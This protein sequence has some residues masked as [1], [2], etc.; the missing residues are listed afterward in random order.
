MPA[1]VSSVSSASLQSA[2][3]SSSSSRA[4]DSDGPSFDDALGKAQGKDAQPADASP[5]T[6]VAR[7]AKADADKT[8]V[9]STDKKAA[10]TAQTTD[11]KAKKK[12]DSDNPP[13]RGNKGDGGSSDG[14]G[15]P[16]ADGKKPQPKTPA[17]AKAIA[18]DAPAAIL[19][20]QGVPIQGAVPQAAA[21]QAN[22]SPATAQQPATAQPTPTPQA[23]AKVTAVAPDGSAAVAPDGSAA[24]APDGSAAVASTP[25][26]PAAKAA[27]PAKD[28]AP[29]PVDS[30]A[31]PPSAD[32]EMA[33]IA[34]PAVD[35]TSQDDTQSALQTPQK[36]KAVPAQVGDPQPADAA[37]TT[38]IDPNF[39]QAIVDGV[40]DAI[41]GS[42]AVS[43]DDI[44]ATGDHKSAR[45]ND[46]SA[47]QLTPQADGPRLRIDNTI[48]AAPGA[49]AQSSEAQFAQ[50]NHARIISGIQEKLL[51]GGGSM[52]IRLDPPELGAVNIKVE[53]RNGVMTASFEAANSDTARLLS[54]SLGDL[55]TSLEA[56]G[57][58]VEKMH[59]TQMP[60]SQSSSNKGDPKS[61]QDTNADNAS[62][63]EQQRRDMMRRM[64]RKLMKG[65]DPLDLVA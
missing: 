29:Q 36:G 35:P 8:K 31:Q 55:K 12:A 60:K 50:V 47:L 26:Q 34:V 58:N 21:P 23:I 6:P 51:P 39:V 15:N 33:A 10:D 49:P 22:A 30:A 17:K 45:Q 14:S 27:A 38:N 44:A 19:Q 59:V 13:D 20:I 16:S 54:H 4:S 9:A 64:W 61:D 41:A 46:T 11:T 25:A 7:P 5:P 28:K 37:T 42:S 18:P 1:T 48:A 63:Q 40:D 53:M 43:P 3:P 56:Q 62:R 57:V 2:R 24:V 65:Q 52:Q 32:V